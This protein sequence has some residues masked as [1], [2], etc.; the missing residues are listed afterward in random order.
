[1]EGPWR[2]GFPLTSSPSAW[3]VTNSG[4]FW[5]IGRALGVGVDGE[6]KVRPM[7]R[8]GGGLLLFAEGGGLKGSH[9]DNHNSGASNMLFKGMM[10]CAG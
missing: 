10:L 8:G 2:I 7:D 6:L 4:L 3:K 5:A 9:K 1:M